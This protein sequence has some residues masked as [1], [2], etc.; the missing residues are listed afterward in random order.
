VGDHRARSGTSA[1]NR[2]K[3]SPT[4]KFLALPSSYS[5]RD[6]PVVSE[7]W[8]A[9]LLRSGDH[10]E[11]VDCVVRR[12]L[13]VID[14]DAERG[15]RSPSIASASMSDC[16]T[17]NGSMDADVKLKVKGID[18]PRDAGSS[19]SRWNAELKSQ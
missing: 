10:I 13:R 3:S 11:P 16:E 19:F 17:N 1:R 2:L 12:R 9:R 6:T 4:T 15:M 18:S 14:V 5:L 8:S 7:E